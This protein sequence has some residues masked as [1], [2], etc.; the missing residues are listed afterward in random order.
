MRIT[1]D[2]QIS[3]LKPATKPFEVGVDRIRGLCVRVFPTGAKQFEYR[4]VALNGSRRR[5]KLGAY[6]GLSLADARVKAALLGVQVTSGVD[7]AAER[8]AERERARNGDTFS[9]LA[10]AIGRRRRSAFAGDVSVPSWLPRSRRSVCGGATIL[11]P[12][13][14]NGGSRSSNERTSR[15]HA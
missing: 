10:G 6:P 1:T 13:S 2:R 3:T 12:S 7:P 11:R 5:H 15:F 14:V 8:L 9:E 4:Y